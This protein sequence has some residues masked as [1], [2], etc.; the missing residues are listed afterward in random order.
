MVEIS[1]EVLDRRDKGVKPLTD[2]WYM[3]CGKLLS[4]F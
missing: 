3:E 1:V 4:R 2:R